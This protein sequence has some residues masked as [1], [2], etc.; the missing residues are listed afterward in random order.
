MRIARAFGFLSG[1]FAFRSSHRLTSRTESRLL[2]VDRA[3]VS[4]A[5]GSGWPEDSSEDSEAI[6]RG[7]RV[8]EDGNPGAQNSLGLRFAAGTGVLRSDAEARKW[9]FRAAE[10]GNAEGQFNLGNLLYSDSV[11]YLATGA[12]EARVQAYM[13]FHLA[14]AQGHAQAEASCETLNLQLTDSEL[15]EGTRRAQA[16]QCRKEEAGNRKGQSNEGN[17]R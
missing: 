10:Q 14:S 17:Q 4:P 3:P 2:G 16:F 8:A 6:E 11:R 15:L 12:G 9:F 7:R 5:H 1:L 13:W